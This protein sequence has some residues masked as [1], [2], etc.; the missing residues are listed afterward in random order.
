LVEDVPVL[1]DYNRMI[2]NE[3]ER[4]AVVEVITCKMMITVNLF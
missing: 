2:T 4:E 1:I 3:A